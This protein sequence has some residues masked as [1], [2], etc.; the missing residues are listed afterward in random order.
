MNARLAVEA[1]DRGGQQDEAN[2]DRSRAQFGLSGHPSSPYVGLH[3]AAT[4]TL[5]PRPVACS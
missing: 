2:D 1:E 4:G 3:N 5:G